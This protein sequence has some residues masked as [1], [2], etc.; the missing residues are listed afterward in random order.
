MDMKMNQG[1][2]NFSKF[3]LL[4]A[5]ELLSAIGGGLTS[6]GLGVYVF[7]Q[8]GS[9]ASMALVTL[10][11]FLP[12]VFLSVPAGVLADRYDRRVLMMVGDGC[13]A[14]GILYILI[15]MITGKA[16]LYQICIGVFVSSV[17]SA[18]LEPAYR[19]TVTD[20]LTKE[21]YSKA[22]GMV[23]IAGSARYLVSPVL[24][25]VLLAVSD[26]RTLLVIDIFTFFLTVIA[27]AV[28]RKKMAVK[29]RVEVKDTFTDSLRQGWRT[30][31]GSRGL[32]LLILV[33]M[34]ITCFM[35]ICQTLAQPMILD[36][37]DSA[38]LGI[39]ETICACGMLVTS[40]Y[41]GA[42]GIK[43]GY[44]RTLSLSLFLA[45]I[46]MVGFGMWESIPVIC[47][48][49]FV[50]FAMLPFA[51]NCLDYLVRTNIPD[52]QQG[53]A[54]GI[55]GFISQM[56]YIVAYSAA[57]IISDGIAVQ[58]EISVGRGAASVII[59][60]GI[61]LSITAVALYGKKSIRMLEGGA[62]VRVQEGRTGL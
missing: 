47:G 38:V 13:S 18:L 49:G 55:I 24:A 56:G 7:S 30:I 8:T 54:W 45:G 32:L 53:R 11:A 3:M 60:A 48:F 21:E 17:F 26:I 51:N 27:A 16:A 25:G 36:F 12:T 41:L 57:G 50:F 14:L 2:S 35:G 39:T 42:K 9:A 52:K 1:K 34:A 19:A 46:G 43:G 40:L 6:F 58:L 59:L 62:F 15:C 10:L 20:L 5:G 29:K 37:S 61:L 44:V 28:V 4:W 33:S 23:S 22:S 31:S